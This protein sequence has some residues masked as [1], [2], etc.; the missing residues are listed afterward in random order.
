MVADLSRSQQIS[1]PKRAAT[2]PTVL[3]HC[4]CHIIAQYH[5][6][7][8]CS[9]TYSGSNNE[10]P[11]QLPQPWEQ[12]DPHAVPCPAAEPP[13][14][15]GSLAHTFAA[16]QIASARYRSWRASCIVPSLQ[17]QPCNTDF[18]VFL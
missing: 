5:T 7:T 3:P 11:L 16:L 2:I 18:Y 15:R 10:L 1:R 4:P 8:P 13:P 12:G 9:T 14:V 17:Q 6:V